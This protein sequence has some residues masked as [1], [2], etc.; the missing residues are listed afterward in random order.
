[1][2]GD[3]LSQPFAAVDGEFSSRFF[4]QSTKDDVRQADIRRVGRILPALKLLA[5]ERG[6][7]VSNGVTVSVVIG[8]S[9]LDKDLP[10]FGAASCPARHLAEELKATLRRT[11]IRQIDSDV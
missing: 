10:S 7:V 3:Q 1:T 2:G 9:C 11:E 8:K 6:V 5:H 4:N